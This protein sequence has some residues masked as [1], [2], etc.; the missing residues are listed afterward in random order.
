MAVRVV[1]AAQTDEVVAMVPVDALEVV[2]HEARAARLELAIVWYSQSVPVTYWV[3]LRL[4]L[5]IVATFNRN[6]SSTF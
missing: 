1:E 5:C 4:A 3:R 6:V 2:R